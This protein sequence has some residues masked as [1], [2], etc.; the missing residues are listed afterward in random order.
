MGKYLSIIKT[1][2]CKSLTKAGQVLGYTQPSLS[3]IINN[4][5]DEL[6]C[7]LFYRDQRGVVLTEMGEQL[8]E[9]MKQIEELEERIHQLARASQGG[10]LRVGIFPSVATQW[11]PRILEE[12]YQAYPKA[13]VKLEHM[14][15]YLHG[16]LGV[17]EHRLDCCFFVGTCPRGL[18]MVPLFEDRY[19][20][21]VRQGDPLAGKPSVSV[22]ELRER[23]FIPNSESADECSV[24]REVCQSLGENS[25]FDFT[26]QEDATCIAMVEQGLGVTILSG[27]SMI[28]LIPGKDVAAVPLQEDY[29]R[30]IG[31]L[32]PPG[33]KRSPLVTAFLRIVQRKVEEW[34][35]ENKR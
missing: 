12:F 26:P 20:C 15:G 24:L 25:R 6:G 34:E 13:V 1:A 2:E 7:K 30:G 27:L 29:T 10:L 33:A 21:L 11:M 8:L 28:D 35:E 16:E 3:Y 31:L 32:C 18:E 17:R 22:E 14:L 4:I 19:F 5:E 9:Y 23:T